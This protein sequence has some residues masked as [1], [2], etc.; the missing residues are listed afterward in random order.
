MVSNTQIKPTILSDGTYFVDGGSLFGSIP[1][2]IWNEAKSI[3]VLASNYH[4]HENSLSLLNKKDIGIVS[5]YARGRDYHLT[6][7]KR[8]KS[9]FTFLEIKYVQKSL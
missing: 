5:V 3:L 1:K 2:N 4:F 8:L 6:I 7:K 9:Y